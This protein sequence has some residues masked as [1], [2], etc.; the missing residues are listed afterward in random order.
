MKRSNKA[1]VLGAAVLVLVALPVGSH[2]R[3]KARAEAY[4]RQLQASGEPVDLARM[5]PAFSPEEI[6]VGFELRAAAGLFRGAYTSAPSMKF[7]APGRALAVCQE[8]VL[9]T[10]ES[11][12][13][14][15][16]LEFMLQ[17]NQPALEKLRAA[18]AGSDGFGFNLD[19][20]A[21][22]NLLLPHLAQ[23]KASVQWLYLSALIELR[24]GRM[25]NAWEDLDA[26]TRIATGFR[27]ESLMIS[28]LVRIAIAAIAI[29]PSWE[30]LQR[31]GWKD[32][33]LKSLQEQWQQLD[34][35][36]QAEAV[37]RTERL[38]LAKTFEAGR[39]SFSAVN[40]QPGAG[41]SGFSELAQVGKEIVN[42]PGKGFA[43]ALHRYPGYWGWRYWQSYEDEIAHG[44]II[45]A[46][47]DAVRHAR[48]TGIPAAAI[49][50]FEASA[51]RV[52]AA[53]PSAFKWME[54]SP[55]T[56]HK[57]FL[58]RIRTVEIER[59][60]LIAALALK[61]YEL[62]H[63]QYPADLSALVPEFVTRLP[64]DPMD[65]K[66]LRYR[67]NPDGT[68]L[69]YSIGENGIDNGGN[70]APAPDAL[71][72][73]WRARD[74]VWPW[75]ATRA[76]VQAEFQ[77]AVAEHKKRGAASSLSAMEAFRRRYG[78][79]PATNAPMR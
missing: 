49:S 14:W 15:P 59:A 69:L 38:S 2:Y 17:Q 10:E 34:L 71:R 23:L 47:I 60:L 35:L 58:E 54:Y 33:Q 40:F 26:L 37:L 76:E 65:G 66:P 13:L 43:A 79:M 30:A 8:E 77:R 19:Y 7:L 55:S 32:E 64:R 70:P 51:A 45:Q 78:L 75:P 42:D 16:G 11:T 74:A 50:D 39:H 20:G 56:V 21:G 68:F 4:R 1:A 18:M 73:W 12:N 28:E 61:R 27:K 9:P 53:Y 57:R 3:A 63:G 24:A 31:N 67:L 44:K 72:Q 48:T 41:G 62:K 36:T 22:P 6:R 5:Q 29:N 52:S 25:T 46:A